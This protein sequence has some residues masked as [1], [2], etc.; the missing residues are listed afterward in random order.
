MSAGHWEYKVVYV[1][2]WHRVSI[3]GDESYP[4]EGERQSGFGRRFLNSLGADGWELTGIQHVMPG[5]SYL[6]FKRP[7]AEGSEP[8]LSVTRNA[9]VREPPRQ[10]KQPGAA[11]GSQATAL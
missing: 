1:E 3:E 6:I 11:G 9:I 4:E 7:L 2:G 10:G 8:D 5:R